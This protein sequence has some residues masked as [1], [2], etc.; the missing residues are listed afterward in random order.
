MSPGRN[1]MAEE[2]VFR[3]VK[4]GDGWAISS[5]SVPRDGEPK[6][7]EIPLPGCTRH[8]AGRLAKALNGAFELGKQTAVLRIA[9]GLQADRKA[10]QGLIA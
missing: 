3:V 9:R 1:D 8:E 7:T 10:L 6:A 2:N 5:E 4:T